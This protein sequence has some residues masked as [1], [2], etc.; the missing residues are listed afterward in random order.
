M[1][2]VQIDQLLLHV[3]ASGVMEAR[4][5]FGEQVVDVFLARALEC[6]ANGPGGVR[7]FQLRRELTCK[8]V[9]GEV[10]MADLGA[11]HG[12]IGLACVFLELGQGG[13][14]P[15]QQVLPPAF[16]EL[17]IEIGKSGIGGN[18]LRNARIERE[19]PAACADSG[20]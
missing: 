15:L 19:R 11:K 20:R 13:P 2:Q 8:L 9:G 18:G 17:L 5:H 12:V 10:G 1:Q 14:G 6:L 3:V 7:L 16:D 4:A